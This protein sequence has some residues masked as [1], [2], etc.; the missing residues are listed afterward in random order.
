MQKI[1]N[2]NFVPH[3]IFSKHKTEILSFFRVHLNFQ[4]FNNYE[5]IKKKIFLS[6][7]NFHQIKTEIIAKFELFIKSF[8]IYN[9]IHV[10]SVTLRNV[11]SHLVISV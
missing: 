1:L 8:I 11:M 5:L 7:L 10:Q 4:K 2:E 9:H 6:N 3:G